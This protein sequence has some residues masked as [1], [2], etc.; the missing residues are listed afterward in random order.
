MPVTP[1]VVDVCADCAPDL[2][3]VRITNVIAHLG[4]RLA[5]DPLATEGLHH[6]LDSFEALYDQAEAALAVAHV[7]LTEGLDPLA[8]HAD[9]CADCQP[10]E[11]RDT[12]LNF[13]ALRDEGEDLLA[14]DTYWTTIGGVISY[15][16]GWPTPKNRYRRTVTTTSFVSR[17][18]TVERWIREGGVTKLVPGSCG[19]TIVTYGHP[20]LVRDTPENGGEVTREAQIDAIAEAWND[21]NPGWLTGNARREVAAVALEALDDLSAR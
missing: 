11:P 5:D 10:C 17:E 7:T 6:I 14:N 19:D 21:M 18:D 9:D 16:P 20:E 8:P 3:W 4:E 1:P 2:D 13:T 12:P 15:A